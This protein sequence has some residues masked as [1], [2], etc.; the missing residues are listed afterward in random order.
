VRTH[1]TLLRARQRAGRI[2]EG[3]GD[4]HTEHVCFL[5]APVA[6]DGD[7][8][9]LA[10][11]IYVFDCIEFSQPLRCNDVAYEVAFLA[12]D[13]ERLEQPDLAR[14]FVTAYAAVANDPMVDVLL[15]F[16]ASHLACV[17]GKVEALKSLEPEVEGADRA[18][19]E[20]RARCDFALAVRHA[21]QAAGPAV[22]ACCGLSGSGKTALAAELAGRTG[23]ALLGTDAIRRRVAPADVAPYGAGR[24]TASA[25]EAVYEALCVEADAALAAG[26]GVIADATFLRA[27]DRRRLAAVARQ[28]RRPC[29]FVECRA[30]E[31][32]IRARLDARDRARSL[33]DARWETYLGQRAQ[34]EPLR[35]DEPHI[36][37][38]ASGELETAR[39]A[40]LRQ[41]WRW[42]Q[43]RPLGAQ[44]PADPPCC[45]S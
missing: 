37:V 42:R 5:D 4:L 11:G 25:R 20:A 31:E 3:H 13:L 9:P 34:H 45:T 35:P 36:V 33:S 10:P 28:H 24:Y 41:L 6:G 40:A 14:R 29:I 8:P 12:M 43:G 22:I 27:A 19:T 38:E 15:P 7:R 21:W 1:E 26:Q 32:V 23:F 17:R 30:D 18:A 16:Y 39:A 44:R 2:R